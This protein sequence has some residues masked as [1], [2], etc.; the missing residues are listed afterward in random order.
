MSNTIQI[1]RGIGKPDEKLAPYELGIQTDDNNKIFIGGPDGKLSKAQQVKVEY[2]VTADKAAI[3]ETSKK[4][5]NFPSED[6]ILKTTIIGENATEAVQKA[7]NAT[8]AEHATNATNSSKL[9]NHTYTQ[10]LQAIYPVGAIYISTVS[11]SPATLFGFGT[12]ERI[13]NRFLLAAGSIY[14][15]GSTGG[16]A[17]HTLT[18][19]QIP[20]HTHGLTTGAGNIAAGA[21]NIGRVW[22]ENATTQTTGAT[23]G[24]KAHN[25]MPP[26]LAV[27]V[28][29]RTK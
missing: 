3:A 25:N 16:A 2:A 12:W 5:G 29:E 21:T 17:T 13:Q 11:T 4:L 23:G 8:N 1:K 22:G 28:W 18:V 20:S 14:S 6:Y 26:Y 7:T 24:S 15:A 9:E 27:Y 10:I 19:E